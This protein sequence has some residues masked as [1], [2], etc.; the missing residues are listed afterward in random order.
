MTPDF[1]E[2]LDSIDGQEPSLHKVDKKLSILIFQVLDVLEK[3]NDIRGRVKA[4]EQKQTKDAGFI[5]GVAAFGSLVITGL[6]IWI[7][8]KK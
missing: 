4:I 6:G 2:Q 5:K 3:Y 7:G 1:K 8:F